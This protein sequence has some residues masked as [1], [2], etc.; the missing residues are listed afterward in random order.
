MGIDPREEGGT[1][2]SMYMS[3]ANTEGVSSPPVGWLRYDRSTGATRVC[4]AP[5][6]TFT[7][8]IVVIPKAQGPGCWLA[9]MIFN[10]ETDRSGLA[11]LDGEKIE[12]GPVAIAWLRGPTPHGLHGCFVPA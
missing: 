2:E 10:A 4:R 12:D 3:F 11:I 6:R 9:G 8:E 7:E 1:V 5:P